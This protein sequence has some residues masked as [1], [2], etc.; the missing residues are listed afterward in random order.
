MEEPKTGVHKEACADGAKVNLL[1]AMSTWRGLVLSAFDRI[2]VLWHGNVCVRT[3]RRLRSVRVLPC[4]VLAAFVTTAGVEARLVGAIEVTSGRTNADVASVTSPSSPADATSWPFA[5]GSNRSDLVAHRFIVSSGRDSPTT[6]M[7]EMNDAS[8]YFPQIYHSF[9]HQGQDVM[10]SKVTDNL[11]EKFPLRSNTDEMTTYLVSIG[12]N[13]ITHPYIK[14]AFDCRFSHMET[15]PNLEEY[16]EIMEVIWRVLIR[17][18]SNKYTKKI[19][20][21]LEYIAP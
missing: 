3:R 12:L 7:P 21:H 1:S 8:I 15:I 11:L 20:V 9:R 10:E 2:H 5:R 13:C 19:S 4:L 16:G 18:D 14:N 17:Y 6:K